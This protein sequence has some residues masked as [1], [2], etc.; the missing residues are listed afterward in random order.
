[1]RLRGLYFAP[2]RVG[3]Y[4]RSGNSFRRPTYKPHETAAGF[5]GECHGGFWA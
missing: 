3:G 4:Q 2:G 5:G 1:M